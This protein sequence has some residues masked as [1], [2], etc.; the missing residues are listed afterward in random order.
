LRAGTAGAGVAAR[1]A[2]GRF[3]VFAVF[4]G[5]ARAGATT[6]GKRSSARFDESFARSPFRLIRRAVPAVVRKVT[7]EIGIHVGFMGD[8]LRKSEKQ[9]LPIADTR[10]IPC[11]LKEQRGPAST[12]D[13][14]PVRCQL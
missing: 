6:S 2:L 12:S 9:I 7:A 3:A 1:G 5:F 10:L 8:I 14:G 4:V 11:L 13:A